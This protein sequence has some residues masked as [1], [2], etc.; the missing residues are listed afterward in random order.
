MKNVKRIFLALTASLAVIIL[1]RGWIY[2][3]SV[4]YAI[5]TNRSAYAPDKSFDNF[6]DERTKKEKINS[7][8]DIIALSLKITSEE[9]SFTTKKC[10]Y[11]PSSLILSPK[12]NCIGYSAFF[13]STCNY[14]L[15]KYGYGDTWKAASLVGQLYLFGININT[16]FHS[17]FFKDHD[18]NVIENKKT[19]EKLYIDPTV[20][21]YLDINFI[22]S[23]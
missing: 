1:F 16:H 5:L 21:D 6:I 22:S 15:S 3:H 13:T 19:G 9:L 14:L 11:N 4:N 18:F 2:R 12:T 7:V 20:N 10:E 17:S 23:N 8:D